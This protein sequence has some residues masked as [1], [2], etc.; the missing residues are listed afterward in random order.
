MTEV[1][2]QLYDDHE[3]VAKIEVRR[4]TRGDVR[5][6]GLAISSTSNIDEYSAQYVY[7]M[8]Q[9]AFDQVMQAPLRSAAMQ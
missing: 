1:Y 8:G 6:L 2:D 9:D 5:C 4:P 7:P 3:F